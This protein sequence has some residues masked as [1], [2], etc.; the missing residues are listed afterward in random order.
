[1][2]PQKNFEIAR[3]SGG[4]DAAAALFQTHGVGGCRLDQAVHVVSQQTPSTQYGRS[5]VEG[6]LT[7]L[8]VKRTVATS[9]QDLPFAAIL[10]LYQK[11]LQIELPNI[12]ALRTRRPE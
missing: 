7:H 2:N 11:V 4:E 6:F 5:E 8:A 10:F 3:S 9:T 1:V 12:N